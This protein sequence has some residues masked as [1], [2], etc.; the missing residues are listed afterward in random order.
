MQRLDLKM[1]VMVATG[2]QVLKGMSPV[3]PMLDLFVRESIQNSYDALLP[4]EK[5]LKE[6]FNCG[7]FDYETLANQFDGISTDL[8]IR[9]S[10]FYSNKYMAVRDYYA[11]GL[12]GP[13]KVEDIQ[14]Q[15]WGRFLNLVRNFGKSQKVAGAGGSWGYGKTT[16][17]KIGVGLVIYYS[18]ILEDGEYKE[19]LM[20]CLVENETNKSGLLYRVQEG[21]NTGIAWWGNLD[22]DDIL[23]I[24][25]HDEIMKILN[26]FNYKPYVGDETGTAVIVPYI[27]EVD[28]LNKTSTGT[29]K[30]N[31][32]APWCYSIEDYLKV[33]FQRWYPTRCNNTTKNINGIDVYINGKMIEKSK[34]R[35]LFKV[36]QDLY[37]KSC[38]E[39]FISKY[40][41]NEEPIMYAVNNPF[42]S[43]IAGRFFYTLLDDDELE[44][45]P[46]N[47]EPSPYTA[48]TNEKDYDMRK[49][50]ICFCR[51]PGMILKYDNDGDWAGAIT[52]PNPD[53]FLIG[54]FVPNSS[55]EG[56]ID[57]IRFTI[58]DYLRASESAEHNNWRDISEYTIY[59]I[60]KKVDCSK[61]KLVSL[62]HRRIK[63]IFDQLKAP[64]VLED[65]TFVGSS[66]N[67]KLAS[68]F[69]P[70]KGFGSKPTPGND[71]PEKTTR[72]PSTVRKAR[73]ELSSVKIINDA[74]M[75]EF[76]IIFNKNVNSCAIEFRINTE[77]NDIAINEWE[78][79]AN[80]PFII[81]SIYLNQ[82]ELKNGNVITLNRELSND[83][84]DLWIS[85]KKLLSNKNNQYGFILKL[86]NDEVKTVK[87]KINYRV[88]DSTIP[89]SIN[90]GRGE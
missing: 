36:V 40:E 75:K 68:L 46:P 90:E 30:D 26:C 86:N 44:M 28:L 79:L 82:I 66:L 17:Y 12:T 70:K 55:N 4:G 8:K 85:Y 51:K 61:V 48:A 73:F 25:N 13:L 52:S 50:L 83:Y 76:N 1:A 35:P 88:I 34:M 6:E 23:P 69:L 45:T 37:S 74:Y 19:R 16:F 49:I 39:D 71:L 41:I 81:N 33:S 14:G 64:A 22:G 80:I 11:T 20:A 38:G 9:A 78:S 7:E 21:K 27:D 56:E 18:R 89:I 53:K 29:I 65:T 15:D 67:R 63:A 42:N 72:T 3:E 2:N 87:G 59:E 43:K 47:N 10:M 31:N 5:T 84:A 57:G 60:G 77:S 54:L 32:V 58:D 24:T 62:I